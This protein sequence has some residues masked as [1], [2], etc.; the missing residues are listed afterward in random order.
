M[1]PFLTQ[2]CKELKGAKNYK[3]NAL[4][5]HSLLALASGIL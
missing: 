3:E 5:L 1:A 2:G 4:P